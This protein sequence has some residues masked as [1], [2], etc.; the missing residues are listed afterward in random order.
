M[1]Q[2]KALTI[3]LGDQFSLQPIPLQYWRAPATTP[4]TL[5]TITQGAVVVLDYGQRGA[6]T[7]SNGASTANTAR[8]AT[9]STPNYTANPGDPD[10][11]M[12][13]CIIA[14]AVFT[15]ASGA[16]PRSPSYVLRDA[17]LA[18]GSVGSFY[19]SGI[20]KCQVIGRTDASTDGALV[21]G[22]RLAI[23]TEPTIKG[24]LRRAVA[25]ELV[26]AELLSAVASA[27]GGTTATLATVHFYGGSNSA[28][29]STTTGIA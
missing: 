24:M 25:N 2:E 11:F 9:G 14:D 5:A 1:A 21:I 17:S 19:G 29:Q 16:V 20:I 26:V 10:C 23:A 13:N 28:F 4:T 15:T 3:G 7:S 27:S 18:A 12:A 22:E 6:Y 8:A